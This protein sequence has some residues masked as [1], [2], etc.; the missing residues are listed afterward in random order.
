MQRLTQLLNILPKTNYAKRL[1]Q[2]YNKLRL[3]EDN[4]CTLDNST[5]STNSDFGNSSFDRRNFLIIN[6]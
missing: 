2:E 1:T 6:A 3:G 5:L 4:E